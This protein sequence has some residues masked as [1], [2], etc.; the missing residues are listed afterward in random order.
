M[1]ILEYMQTQRK[2]IPGV[3]RILDSLAKNIA[4]DILNLHTLKLE[5]IED[6]K[7][8]INLHKKLGFKEEG[9]L[10]DFVYKDGK[11]KDVIIMGIM[12]PKEK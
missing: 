3:G 4:F 2:K 1:L 5:V 10:K 6:N 8:V 12:N 11:W 7:V 9:R